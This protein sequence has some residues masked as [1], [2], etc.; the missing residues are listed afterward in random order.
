MS[1]LPDQMWLEMLKRPDSSC[2]REALSAIGRT[3]NGAIIEALKTIA[4]N[5]PDPELRALASQSLG[6]SSTVPA[7]R[8]EAS[9]APFLVNPNNRAFVAGTTTKL[10]GP[11]GRFTVAGYWL[12]LIVFVPCVALISLLAVQAWDI[13]NG[14]QQFGLTVDGNAVAKRMEY[15]KGGEKSGYAYYVTYR[16]LAVSTNGESETFQREQEVARS[17][18]DGIEE[19]SPIKVRYNTKVPNISTLETTAGDSSQATMLTFFAGTLILTAVGMIWIGVRYY[20]RKKRLERRHSPGWRTCFMQ[21]P[22]RR[23]GIVPDRRGV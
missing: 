15:H 18:Y 17:I 9:G 14:L 8:Q 19:G 22:E 13:Y 11:P 10:G 1:D 2:R 20:R 21:G 5:D 4:N 7:A 12:Y 6:Q 16:F 3:Q 23:K